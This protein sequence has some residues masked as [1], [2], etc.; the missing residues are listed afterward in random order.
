MGLFSKEACTFCG[1]EVG[2]LKRSKLATKEFICNDCRNKTNYFARMDYTTRAAAQTMMETMAGEEEAFEASFKE[3]ENGFDAAEVIF[4]TWDLGRKRIHYRANKTNGGFQIK[5]D[6]Y[7]HYDCVPVLYF[8]CVIPYR[9]VADDE[10]F[11]E[12]R[13]NEIMNQNAD[14]A[15]VEISKDDEG[16]VNHCLLTIPYNDNCIREIKLESD[17]SDEGDVEAFKDFANQ[18]NADRRVWLARG[19]RLIDRKNRMQIRNLA[20]TATE[21]L[22]AAATGG[23]IEEA[24]KK[25]VETANDIEEGRV[26]QGFFGK[27]FKK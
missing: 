26:K 19:A 1:T 18:F 15:E 8:D 4:H 13:R 22:K 7:S 5:L 14:Y 25:G 27:L 17:V 6:E 12:S 11:T 3:A 9:F 24:I 21:A 16:K 20:D 23:D 10:S 2:M